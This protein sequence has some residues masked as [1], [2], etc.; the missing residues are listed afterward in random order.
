MNV[1]DQEFAV[2][3]KSNLDKI[4]IPTILFLLGQSEDNLIRN[5]NEPNRFL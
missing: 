1:A 5:T 2:P 4:C 3:N